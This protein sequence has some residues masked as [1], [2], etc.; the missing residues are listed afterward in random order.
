M[1][2]YE[3][4]QADKQILMDISQF[5]PHVEPE[6]VEGTGWAPGLSHLSATSLGMYLR[7]P[8]QFRYRYI[9]GQKK[10]PGEALVVGRAVHSTLEVNFAEKVTTHEDMSLPTLVEFY[11]DAAWP[12]CIRDEEAG[13]M[14]ILWDK[15]EADERKRGEKMVAHYHQAISPRVQPIEAEESFAIEGLAPVPVIGY[16]DVET[17]QVIVDFKT[18]RQLRRNVRPDWQLQG[19]L[20]SLAKTKP[21]DFHVL[22]H[23]GSLTP[24]EEPSLSIV[25]TPA[26]AQATEVLVK[27]TVERIER[28]YMTYGPDEHWPTYGSINEMYNKPICSFCGWSDVCPGGGQV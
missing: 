20:Y 6:V 4:E 3:Q 24:L 5:A 14:E 10:R 21:I 19:R 13:G 11:N 27:A 7:C 18:A 9:L 22:A 15:G 16:L 8:N 28:D 1:D 17:D 25:P 12:E 23:T 2:A 26:E